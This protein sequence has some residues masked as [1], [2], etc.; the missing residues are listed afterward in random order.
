MSRRLPWYFIASIT[1]IFVF[2]WIDSSIQVELHKSK[3]GNNTFL[4]QQGSSPVKR[5]RSAQSEIQSDTQSNLGHNNEF[6]SK[7]NEEIK[8][9]HSLLDDPEL[10]EKRLI[11]L[12]K[13]VTDENILFLD[14]VL[15]NPRNQVEARQLAIDILSLSGKRNAILVLSQYVQSVNLKNKTPEEELG[16]KAM[17]IE[18][19]ASYSD[20]SLAQ[21]SL[22][23]IRL[24]TQYSFV[25]DRAVKALSFLKGGIHNLETNMD[26]AKATK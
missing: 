23:E 21:K 4:S 5:H 19:I 13:E 17:A 18:G 20:K 2:V 24:R 26:E 6:K 8:Q 15:R 7:F 3:N 16:L 25:L 10:A 9:S 14:G 1:F 12:A 22:E 11:I